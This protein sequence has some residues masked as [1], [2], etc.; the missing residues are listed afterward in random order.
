[1]LRKDEFL[2]ESKTFTH[3]D[4][5]QKDETFELS[6]GELAF[7]Y[8]QVPIIYQLSEGEGVEIILKDGKTQQSDTRILDQ[9]TCNELFSRSGQIQKIKVKIPQSILK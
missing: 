3:I 1:M 5:A 4:V 6:T 2:S 9:T 7:S 8:C